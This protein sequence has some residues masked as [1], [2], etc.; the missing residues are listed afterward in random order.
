MAPSSKPHTEPMKQKSL[1][2][3]FGKGPSATPNAK[4]T[5]SSAKLA[6]TSS[7]RD[8]SS[9]QLSSSQEPCTPESKSMN[10][11]ALNSSAM[12]G[13]AS[14]RGRS[15]PPTSDPIDVDM[16]SSDEDAKRSI[17]KPVSKNPSNRKFV[18]C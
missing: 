10:F 12:G 18:W 17:R 6:P 9:S 11:L 16:V 3:W 2:S 1:M 7:K 13:S 5:K 14:S 4:T 15:T 8:A